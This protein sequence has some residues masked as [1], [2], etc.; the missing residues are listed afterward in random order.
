VNKAKTTINLPIPSERAPG[1][2]EEPK[3]KRHLRD[4]PMFGTVE[5]LK[6]AADGIVEDKTPPQPLGVRYT[7][8]TDDPAAIAQYND[9][10]KFL[11]K[12]IPKEQRQRQE[13]VR[14]RCVEE[15]PY[16]AIAE[17]LGITED[18]ARVEAARGRESIKE[19]LE[20]N[21][22]RELDALLAG[23][24]PPERKA[25]HDPSRNGQPA[26]DLD[27]LIAKGRSAQRLA[28]SK[29]SRI[30]SNGPARFQK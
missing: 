15:K 25:A 24:P 26:V 30:T 21:H 8:G 20:K 28:S 27:D 2:E 23:K 19:S 1:F 22:P 7:A 13:A 6:K 29:H 11:I 3:F 16:R 9:L 10:V 14:L 18:H 12:Q 17:A 4:D 5:A